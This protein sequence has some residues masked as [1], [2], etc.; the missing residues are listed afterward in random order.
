MMSVGLLAFLAFLALAGYG[1]IQKKNRLKEAGRKIRTGWGH[2]PERKYSWEEF[3]RVS[4]YFYRRQED[5]PFYIDDI[6]WNDLDMD[7]IF[8]RV[9]HTWSSAGEEYLYYLMRM[10]FF[11]C[12]EAD[13]RNR[14]ISWFQ[15]EATGREAV[16]LEFCRMGRVRRVALADY[17]FRFAEL[18]GR[19]PVQNWIQAGA[20][21]L[22]LIGM[23]WNPAV[24]VT[25][26]A[27]TAALNIFT[28][29]SRKAEVENF[30][31]CIGYLLAMAD[32]AGNLKNLCTGAVKELGERAGKAGAVFSGIRKYAGLIRYQETVSGS[33]TDMLLDYI[34]MLFHIDLIAF[35]TARRYVAAHQQEAAE[36]YESLGML[37]SCAAIASYRES[38]DGYAVPE[39]AGDGSLRYRGINMYH[40]LIDRPV[41]NS[42]DEE[43]CVLLTG[44][45][46]SGKSTFLK[47]AAVNALFAQTIVTC[48]AD[49]WQ[50]CFYKM[51][52]SMALRDDIRGG[53]SYYMAEIRALKRILDQTGGKIPTLCFVDEVLRGTNTVERIAA[54]SQILKNMPDRRTLCFAATHDIELTCIL[55]GIYHNYHF[56]EEISEKDI[57]FPYRLTPGR[58]ATRNAIK[59]LQLMGYDSRVTEAAEE[60]AKHFMETGEWEI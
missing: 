51:Y 8:Q 15:Q 44:S 2:T 37:E 4:H 10:P 11:D 35:E 24:F 56:E 54:S 53:E 7:Q 40:P 50:G 28:Y 41:K 1:H 38:L 31:S 60:A 55:E 23:L 43:C 6:T 19:S 49:S 12:Q 21:L 45:N 3:E 25:V 16:Q 46:A 47:T 14:L 48:L 34:R 59:L 26:A 5:C 9:N 58:A 29:Y 18:P 22:A 30:F 20:L 52:S 57:Y 42:I 13:R 17:I 39:F 33:L 36:L 27:G 32:A